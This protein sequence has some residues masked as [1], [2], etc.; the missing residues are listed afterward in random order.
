MKPPFK[1]PIGWEKGEPLVIDKL[2]DSCFRLYRSCGYLATPHAP[3]VKG[4]VD[5]LE[6]GS[7][8]E[9]NE[10]SQWW[11]NPNYDTSKHVVAYM[12][13]K[14]FLEM[15]EE[16]GWTFG[17][18][19]VCPDKPDV[20]IVVEMEMEQRD[21]YMRHYNRFIRA[22]APILDPTRKRD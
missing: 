13:T 19:S 20:A 21:K 6:F 17:I 16:G 10:F 9:M 12:T 5:F 1:V 3:L 15:L 18:N 14:E 8:N 22:V 2:S 4:S 11:E 7:R